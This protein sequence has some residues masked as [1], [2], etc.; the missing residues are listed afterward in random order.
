M[1]F[2]LTSD[3]PTDELLL[4]QGGLP[5]LVRKQ[6]AGGGATTSVANIAALTALP[7]AGRVE[8]SQV[9]VQTVGAYWTY[10]T[11]T[12]DSPDGITL[13]NSTTVGSWARGATG[14]APE[15]LLVS[16]W[17]VNAATG[18]DENT[19]APGHPLASFAEIARRMGTTEPANQQLVSV[20]M[21]SPTGQPDTDPWEFVSA[22]SQAF[23]L[24]CSG[25]LTQKFAGALAGIVVRNRATGVRWQMT[26]YAGAAS[27]DLVTNT[28]RG[29]SIAFVVSVAAGVA[30]LTQPTTPTA[31]PWN[32]TAPTNV[33]SWANGDAIVARSLPP[34]R[35][36]RMGCH[37]QSIAGAFISMGIY[38]ANLHSADG[39]E[40][41]DMQDAAQLIECTYE[42]IL[43]LSTD[44][45]VS[46]PALIHCSVGPI[47][48][49]LLLGGVSTQQLGFAAGGSAWQVLAA[50]VKFA[51]GF[52]MF[53]A[54]VNSVTFCD[55][56]DV[57]VVAGAT[58]NAVQ[59]PSSV[60]A[61][62]WG[63]GTLNV[64]GTTVRV[65]GA[66]VTN[67]LIT[68]RLLDNVPTAL[69]PTSAAGTVT[70]SGPRTM[71]S[72]NLD[73]AVGGGGFTDATVFGAACFYANNG[74]S[75]LTNL[76]P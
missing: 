5:I 69:V 27:G 60:S 55:L 67:L 46:G 68:G 61:L 29:N 21:T 50:G 2:D 49:N 18:N 31:F 62:L 41:T 33:D 24:D 16:S 40:G 35:V 59:A 10:H 52:Q 28:T 12:A 71:S 54:N 43:S 26:A 73:A 56:N 70:W 13:V 23:T 47:G 34:V 17:E 22:G 1:T 9:Y 14:V 6:L 66:A 30:T 38:R 19:G 48:S 3:Q 53:G 37:F 15:A 7:T 8:G 4:A 58:L 65:L 39:I 42:G 75:T 36:Q 57:C 63:A 72:A 45:Q 25:A 64:E 44:A 20:A 76:S 51:N 32:G 74:R 11:A